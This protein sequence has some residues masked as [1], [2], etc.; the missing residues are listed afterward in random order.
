MAQP[1]SSREDLKTD[2]FQSWVKNGLNWIGNHR[3]TFFSVVGTIFVV[4]ILAAFIISNFINLRKQAWERYALGHNWSMS[5]DPAKSLSYFD[6]IIQN[7]SHTPAAVYA[8]LSKGDV[9]YREGKFDESI[10][11]YQQCLEKKPNKAIVPFVLESLGAAQEQK[12]NFAAALSAYKQFLQDYSNHYLAP[13]VYESLG[14]SYELSL[15]P[16][17]AK[18]IYEKIITL[19]PNTL[20]SEKAKVRYQI[21][22][23]QPFQT[24]LLSPKETK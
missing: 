8:L 20:W 1:L 22:S 10:A 13:K 17:A 23:P 16:D 7:F 12:G 9:L 2:L 15:N 6:D 14:R 24:P 21:I 11:Q 19:Y 3:Q 18:E 4:G 5:T